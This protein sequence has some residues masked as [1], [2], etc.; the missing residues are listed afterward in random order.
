MSELQN[1][2]ADRVKTFVE[3]IANLA[4]KTAIELLSGTKTPDAP[5]VIKRKPGRPPKSAS[6]AAPAAA[7]PAAAKPAPKAPKAAKGGGRG[8]KRTGAEL[9]KLVARVLKQIQD[10]PGQRMEHINKAIGLPTKDLVLPIK[11]LVSE[12]KIRSTGTR[13]STQYFGADP[14]AKKGPGKKK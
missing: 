6:V 7:A 13:R 9:Y 8:A 5:V 3:D 11:K 4:R 12:G 1:Q 14:A 10:N 2:I